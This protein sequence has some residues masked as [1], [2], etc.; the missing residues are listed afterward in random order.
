MTFGQSLTI[1]VSTGEEDKLMSVEYMEIFVRD[2]IKRVRMQIHSKDG[3][4]CLQID[5]WGDG[6][7]FGVSC[8]VLI[9][10]SNVSLHTTMRTAD[11]EPSL[12]LD[13]FSCS[14][15]TCDEVIEIIKYY[16]EDMAVKRTVMI[17]RF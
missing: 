4:E 6:T 13:I 9:N 2:L 15:F 1:D 16:F 10:T 17:D 7:L 5:K 12:Y 3:H 14:A 11:S 8:C